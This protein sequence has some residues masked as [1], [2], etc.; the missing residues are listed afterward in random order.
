MN[1]HIDETTEGLDAALDTVKALI[2]IL[3]I[4]Y[5]D[6]ITKLLIESINQNQQIEKLKKEQQWE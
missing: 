1:T 3:V 6:E 5:N 4:A 2:K